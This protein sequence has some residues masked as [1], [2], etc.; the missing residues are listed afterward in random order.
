MGKENTSRL[1]LRDEESIHTKGISMV[2][3]TMMRIR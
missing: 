3:A 1:S 2:K